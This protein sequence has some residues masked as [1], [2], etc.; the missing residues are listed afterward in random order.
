MEQL[1]QRAVEDAAR[2]EELSDEVN[3]RDGAILFL[4]NELSDI[5]EKLHELQP[6]NA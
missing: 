1:Q 4:M 6:L 3:S 2:I 5:Q